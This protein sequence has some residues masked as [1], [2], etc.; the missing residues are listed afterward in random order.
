MP[1]DA[2]LL[3]KQMWDVMGPIVDGTGAPVPNP[4]VQVS[5]WAR[6]YVNMLKAAV[7]SHPGTITA[8]SA[9]P[10]VPITGGQAVGGKF[11]VVLGDIMWAEIAAVSDPV[12]AVVAKLETT[13]IA[14]YVQGS[15]MI[16]FPANTVVGNSTATPTSPGP[17]VGG[18]AQNGV[19]A[20]LDG[21]SMASMVS[22]VTGQTGPKAPALYGVVC[23]FT[24]ANAMASYAVGTIQAVCSPAAMAPGIGVGGQIA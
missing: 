11:L 5:A 3:A 14:L 6:G 2:S 10:A 13:A 12:S 17:L 22:S 23:T 1:L 21:S 8:I 9:P 18:Q 15:A 7:F 16:S 19:L 24:M 20:G 4:N